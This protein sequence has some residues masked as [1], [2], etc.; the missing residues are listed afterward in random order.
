MVLCS[1]VEAFDFRT[2]DYVRLL[3]CSISELSIVFDWQTFWV[4]SIA[5]TEPNQ[6]QSNDWS[7]IIVDVRLTMPGHSV[8][9]CTEVR[10]AV[11]HRISLKTPYRITFIFILPKTDLLV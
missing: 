8:D 11:K 2:F 3:K 4:S 7:C 5:I 6:S 1:I 10:K 9:T